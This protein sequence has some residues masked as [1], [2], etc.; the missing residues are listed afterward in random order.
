MN[1]RIKQLAQQAGMYVDLK[2]EP[3]PKWMGA[4]E[5]ELAYARFA[6]LIVEECIREL[7]ISRKCDPY[8][9]D[10]FNCEYN[11]CINEQTIVLKE[12]FGVR[13]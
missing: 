7:E 3:W 13:E 12:H 5:C 9:G 10:L 2:G 11:T 1:D 6:E 4:E 8:T